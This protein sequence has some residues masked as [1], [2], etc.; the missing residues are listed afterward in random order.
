MPDELQIKQFELHEK[1]ALFSFLREVYADNMRQSDERY[2]HWHYCESPFASEDDIPLW[3]AKHGEEI[4][5]QLGAIPVELNVNG[6]AERS[7]WILDMI[8]RI[9]FRR[10]GLAKKLVLAI[11]K[12]YPTM[13]GVNTMEQHAPVML[14]SLGWV[15]AGKINRYSKLVSPGNSVKEISRIKPLRQVV[16]GV[17]SVFQT[18][19]KPNPAVKRIEKFDESFNDLW[20]NAKAQ[21]NCSIT[22]SADFLNWQYV[23][24][25]GKKFD[26]FA[27]YEGERLKGYIVL[28]FR[29]ANAD[30]VISKAAITDI[31]YH[32]GHA[33]AA[34]G[35]VDELL[36][37]AI[38]LAAERRAGSLVTD[39]AD[40]LVEERLPHFGFWPVKNPLQLMTKA[41][42]NQQRLYDI[43]NWFLTRG[44]SDT[45]MFEDPNL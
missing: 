8:I 3:V 22:R 18:K 35:T 40:P 23:D 21:W 43:D 17:F 13:L 34:E 39:I 33:E 15:I 31:C 42:Q 26:I 32:P 14:Q 38:N 1:E 30:G 10:H 45:S 5:G 25:P 29:K 41:E 11:N 24:Q 6:R 16:N 7:V 27:F 9:D 37:A 12:L 36:K 4:V 28:F 44:D 20:Q 19:H 2:W